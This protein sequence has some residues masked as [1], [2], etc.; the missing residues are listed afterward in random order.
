MHLMKWLKLV[1]KYRLCWELHFLNCWVSGCVFQSVSPAPISPMDYTTPLTPSVVDAMDKFFSAV[2]TYPRNDQ[3]TAVS[4]AMVTR[5]D[6]E[7]YYRIAWPLIFLSLIGWNL[8]QNVKRIKSDYHLLVA[9]QVTCMLTPLAWLFFLDISNFFIRWNPSDI[10]RTI[11]FVNIVQ[12]EMMRVG[13]Y[14]N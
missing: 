2:E 8:N 4:V 13:S 10:S 12:R 1:D 14:L 6:N 3:A 5:R 7:P 9:I 11:A